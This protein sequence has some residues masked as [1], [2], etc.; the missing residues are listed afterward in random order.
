MIDRRIVQMQAEG[1]TFHYNVNVGKDIA[2]IADLKCR[3]RRGDAFAGGA[4]KPRDLPDP[5]P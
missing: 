3:I 5:G 1:V 4:E 2:V